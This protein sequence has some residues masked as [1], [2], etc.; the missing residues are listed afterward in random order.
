MA[1]LL[2]TMDIE[3]ERGI[4]IKLNAARMEYIADDGEHYLLNLIDTPGH[5]DFSYEKSRS[6]AACEGALLVVDASQGI[7]AQT[8]A[9]RY[10]AVDQDLEIIPVL[11]K[12]DL[13]AADP[14]RVSTEVE[15]TIGIDCTDA[16]QAS[17]KAGIG[18]RDILEAIVKQVPPPTANALME[19]QGTGDELVPTPQG[20]KSDY[21]LRAL[22]YDSFYESYRGVITYFRVMDGTIG[23]GDRIRF[24]NSGKEYDV[25]ECG[26]MLPAQKQVDRLR[27]EEV[28]YVCASIKSTKDARVGDTVTQARDPAAGAL[29]GYADAVPMVYCGLFP[30]DADQY[31]LLRDSLG[32][33]SLN[34][35][36]L[37]YEPGVLGDGLRIPLRLP[38][39]AAHGDH[40]GAPRAR[41]RPGPHRHGA[42]R[43]V[44]VRNIQGEVTIVDNPARCRTQRR[45]RSASPTCAWR[46]SRPRTTRGPSW[47]SRR[48]AAGA[49]GREVPDSTRT[50]IIY[51]LPLAEVITISSR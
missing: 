29:P 11:N 32:K 1:Q 13:P 8:L 6:L 36:A 45:R 37:Q 40:A 48:A 16:I 24:M 34:D 4:T 26:V 30:V 42:V 20:E 12:I 7:E 47:S 27:P 44:R 9:N 2:D 46:Y 22:I 41:V 49:P 43:R 21:P 23:K 17:A 25:T 38:G 10:M 14:D 18:I 50:S 15:N 51:E 19:G 5:V 35:A 33:L 39:P 31:E 28:G 3:R